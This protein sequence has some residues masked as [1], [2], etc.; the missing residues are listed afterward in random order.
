M[1]KSLLILFLSTTGNLLMASS[2]SRQVGFSMGYFLG[3]FGPGLLLC[4]VG[5]LIYRLI[6]KRKQIF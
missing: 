1:K 3:L 2:F 6:K 5:F 4:G